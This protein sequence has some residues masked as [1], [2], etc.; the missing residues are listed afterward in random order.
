[1]VP[2]S[3]SLVIVVTL[4]ISSD[5][6]GGGGGGGTL[7]PAPPPHRA[8]PPLYLGHIKRGHFAAPSSPNSARPNRAEIYDCPRAQEA[9]SLLPAAAG[10]SERTHFASEISPLSQSSSSLPSLFPLCGT[11]YL[12]A[13]LKVRE[14]PTAP[15][16]FAPLPS[17]P[18]PHNR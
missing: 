7:P 5:S 15:P 16:L 3:S 8:T 9:L 17:S 4:V 10:G 13:A 6:R 1:M 12:T 2:H 11:P 18:P 14:G